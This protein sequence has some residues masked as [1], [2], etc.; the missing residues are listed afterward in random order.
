MAE[1]S[2]WTIV[3]YYN[4]LILQVQSLLK[5]LE[6]PYSDAAAVHGMVGEQSLP[7]NEG[8]SPD[9]DAGCKVVVAPYMSKPPVEALGIQVSW[10]S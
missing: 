3:T 2:S 8:A 5:L 6:T 1:L 9:V 10:S 7:S 4:M